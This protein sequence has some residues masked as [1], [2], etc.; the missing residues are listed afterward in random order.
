M[1]Y[2]NIYIYIYTYFNS[3]DSS[4]VSEIILLFTTTNRLHPS[5]S[6]SFPNSSCSGFSDHLFIFYIQLALRLPL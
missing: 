4:I 1:I 2:Y 5:R 6:S 3:C